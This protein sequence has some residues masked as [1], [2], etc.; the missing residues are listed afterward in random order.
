MKA[1]GYDTSKLDAP[2]AEQPGMLSTLGAS[3][4]KGV[5]DVA[6][7]AQRYLGK[8]LQALGADSVGPWLVND[9]E[10]GKAKMTAELAP[11]KEANPTT[12]TIGEV[13][14]NV[15]ATLP[16]G[17]ALAMPVKAAAKAIPALAPVGN[18]IASAGFTTGTKAAPGFT[19]AAGNMLTRAAGGAITG[20]ASAGL[21]DPE[22]VGMG[23]AIGAALPPVIAG[24]GKAG[25]VVAD[26]WRSAVSKGDKAAT[27]ALLKA[28]NEDPAALVAKLRAAQT[29]VPG[30]PVTVAQALQTPEASLLE[31]V[32]ADSPGSNALQRVLKVEQPAARAAALEAVAPTNAAGAAQAKADTGLAI[33]RYATKERGMSDVAN[34]AQYRGVDPTLS[35]RTPLPVDDMAGAADAFIGSG[36]VGKNQAPYA[37][38][39]EAANIS[40]PTTTP[41]SLLVDAKGVPFTPA[42][43]EAQ[44]ARWD[45]VMR[46]RG[47]LNEQATAAAEKGESQAAAALWQQKAAL[48][49]SI[50]NSLPPEMR[51]RW[52]E[53]NSSHAAMQQRFNTGPQSSIFATR[54]GEPVAQGGEITN[55][56]WRNPEDVASFRRLVADDPSMLAQ[57]RS[58]VTTEG[59]GRE[60]G[61]DAPVL[62]QTFAN[63]TKQNA[64]GLRAAFP[65]ADVNAIEAIAA[66]INRS[67]NVTR[68]GAARAGSDTHQKVS[69]ALSMGLLDSPVL[70]RAAGMVPVLKYA[71]GPGLTWAREAA[72]KSRNNA[73]S[74]MLAN[75]TSAADAIERLMSAGAS[76]NQANAIVQL[77]GKSATRA[78]PVMGAGASR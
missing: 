68:L 49:K 59:L 47:S 29:N 67:Q 11:Y 25:A 42:K 10:T 60:A 54:N 72:G 30:A 52:L 39:K 61:K 13:V 22:A 46:M 48:D 71:T 34:K 65:D 57:F 27:A 78:A 62:G 74:E 38:A 58:M 19:G 37:F 55:K 20:G 9:A 23:A 18:A 31:K 4:G 8:G 28:V 75:S 44:A 56:F 43:T 2:A 64:P 15:A 76:Q 69:N 40:K 50:E 17:G 41:A 35:S 33:G 63:W 51:A 66:D 3:V 5:G 26:A 6:L 77:L 36:S 7:G 73:L 14:G 1:N 70:D 12:A 24:L 53:A 32:V 45:E 16:V 21:V